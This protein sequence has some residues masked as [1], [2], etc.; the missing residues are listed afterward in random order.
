[1]LALSVVW[2]FVMIVA[3]AV[4]AT[5]QRSVA[6]LAGSRDD[7][8]EPTGMFARAKRAV[9]NQREGI[10]LF[11][12]FVLIAAMTQNFDAMTAIGAQ[13]FFYS[14]VAHGLLYLAGVP[15]LR[16]ITWVVGIV[17]TGMVAWPIFF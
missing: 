4:F 15:W 16:T 12:P 17:G 6:Q 5:S 1:M 8:P 9:D 13:I 2:L 11:A 7:L 10:I 3:M 14:R